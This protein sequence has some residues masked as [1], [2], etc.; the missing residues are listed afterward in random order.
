MY[1]YIKS[2]E[3]GIID[4]LPIEI[5]IEVPESIY[6]AV[7]DI[8]DQVFF[9]E[10]NDLIMSLYDSLIDDICTVCEMNGLELLYYH[11]SDSLSPD[12]K[13][14]PSR[15]Y[16]FCVK[17]QKQSGTIRVVFMLRLTDHKQTNK[18]ADGSN[19]KDSIDDK[20]KGRLAKYQ[21]EQA[22]SHENAPEKL[23]P[24]ERQIKIGKT[25]C[26]TY[27][28]AIKVLEQHIKG[29]MDSVAD[30]ERNNR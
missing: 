8:N 25:V 17:G 5:E 7:E 6:A 18:R 28:A 26:R 21:K 2:N 10:K 1:K 29:Y 12:G 23:Y 14:S 9:D 30:A 27:G 13:P 20:K 3:V 22:E 16:D 11:E 19:R 15:Y 4:T 24:F